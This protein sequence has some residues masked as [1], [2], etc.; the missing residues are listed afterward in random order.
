MVDLPEQQ[1]APLTLLPALPAASCRLGMLHDGM[2]GI[3][4]QPWFHGFHWPSLHR[5]Q[6]AA[7][8][9][10]KVSDKE[11]SASTM[12]ESEFVGTTDWEFE[13]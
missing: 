10:P 13:F 8:F 9:L 1:S 6:M 11:M 2:H 3:R 12:P 4:A 5:Q 7:P